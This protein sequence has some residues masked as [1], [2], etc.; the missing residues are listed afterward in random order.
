MAREQ[1]LELD[2]KRAGV[3]VAALRPHGAALRQARRAL[4]ESAEGEFLR[5]AHQRALLREIQS[6]VRSRDAALTDVIQ[7]G[8]GG[9]ALG[10]KALCEALVPGLREPRMRFHFPEN[11]DP[12]SFGA[13]LDSLE[14]GRTLVHVVSKTGSTLETLAQLFA[15]RE[16]WGSEARHFVVTTG[17]RGPL[18]E[19]AERE[20]LPILTFPEDVAGR[21]SVFTASGLLAPAL[22]GV[23]V[24][25]VLFGA[26]A[27]EA[28]CK[29]DP[30]LGPAGRL[31]AIYFTHDRKG[32]RPIHVELIYADALLSLGDWFRQIWAESLGKGGRGPTPVVARGATDQHSQIQLYVDGPDDKV[33]TIVRVA[34]LRTRRRVSRRAEPAVIRGRDLGEIFDAQARGTVEA[35][36]DRGRPVIELRLPQ[37]SAESVGQLLLLQQYQTAL[38][39]ALYEVDAFDQPGVDG[40]KRA[41]LRILKESGSP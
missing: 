2:L 14:P 41:A 8:I 27:M 34:R 15:L 5:L 33:Y 26:R 17:S 20:Q 11:V 18:R 3:A 35:L 24:A 10:A 19:L 25:R 28:R 40:G 1:Q 39:G 38:A 22:C 31:A 13:L 4:D 37:I 16:A 29:K 32:G 12:E 36:I 21:F 6:V 9:S 30:L 23:P 7:L